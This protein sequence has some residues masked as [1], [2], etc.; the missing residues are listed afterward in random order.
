D[1]LADEG[2]VEQNY[3]VFDPST[4][5]LT[6]Q[7]GAL[8]PGT[9]HMFDNCN[10]KLTTLDL[11]VLDTSNVTD[12]T[13]LLNGCQR[14]T[15]LTLGGSFSTA[16]VR[17]MDSMF[18]SCNSLVS[19]DVSGFDTTN[20]Q[21]MCSMFDGCSKLTSL[22]LS[23]FNTLSGS[24]MDNMF[25]NCPAL[26][27]VTLG[28]DFSMLGHDI[29][30]DANAGSLPVPEVRHVQDRCGQLGRQGAGTIQILLHLQR[31]G[32]KANDKDGRRQGA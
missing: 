20:A 30:N 29:W 7:Y 8:P 15:T 3:A 26:Q 9:A 13:G 6:F 5:T 27:S 18:S 23:S 17:G 28:K 16:N 11:S 10:G 31:Q 22:D 4:G 14:L 21:T 19:L 25:G 32:A 12:M 24:F 1:P 2:D